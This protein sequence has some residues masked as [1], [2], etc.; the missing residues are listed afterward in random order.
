MERSQE[1]MVGLLS[2]AVRDNGDTAAGTMAW[3][4]CIVAPAV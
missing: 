4:L 2:K 3:R 1:D